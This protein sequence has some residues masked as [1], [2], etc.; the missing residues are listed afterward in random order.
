VVTKIKQKILSGMLISACFFST[1]TLACTGIQLKDKDGTFVTGRTVEFGIPL[2]L[3]RLVVPRGYKFTGTTPSGND[4]LSYTAK[5]A[6]IGMA[7]FGQPAIVDGFNEKG[8]AGGMFY[9]A[10]SAKYTPLTVQNRKHALAATQFLNWVLT[11]FATVAE[12]KKAVKSVVVV[13]TAFKSWGGVPPM[14]FIVYD[15]SGK[16]VA[17]EPVNGKLLVT[18]DPLGTFTNS[19]S[20]PWHLTNLVNYINLTPKGIGTRKIGNYTLKQFGEGTGL[21]GLPGD[22]TPPSRF[23]RAAIFSTAAVPLANST[24]GS[25]EAFHILNQF[26]IPPGSVTEQGKKGFEITIA[27]TVR[28]TNANKYY[29]RTFSDQNIRVVDFNKFKHT[30]KNLKWVNI[31]QKAPPA[32]DITNRDTTTPQS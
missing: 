7:A 17:I 6:A 10:G 16:S 24:L 12:V 31:D 28:D 8:L 22:F 2:K 25:F 13:P 14:H 32:L 23:I 29:F 26:D 4:G 5:Y 9:F 19:P 3:S 18:D 21:L 1:L 11:N 15:K 20:F 30:D 27:T